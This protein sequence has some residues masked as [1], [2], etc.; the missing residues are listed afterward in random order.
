MQKA[1]PWLSGE[2]DAGHMEKGRKEG[3]R[4]GEGKFLEVMNM[5]II[6]MVVIVA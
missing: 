1:D 5:F 2:W 4:R 6:L 3:L